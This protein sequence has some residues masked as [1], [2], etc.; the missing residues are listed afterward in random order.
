MAELCIFSLLD[1]VVNKNLIKGH[2]GQPPSDV[3]FCGVLNFSVMFE[4]QIPFYRVFFF[5]GSA[6]KVLSVG[7]G[8]ISTKKGKVR[9]KTSHFLCEMPL[10]SLFW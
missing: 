6:L 7:D 9:V 10:L 5:T 2:S 1:E 3:M 8:K 4:S